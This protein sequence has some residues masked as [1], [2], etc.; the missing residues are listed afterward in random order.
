MS[1]IYD[2]LPNRIESEQINIHEPTK[3]AHCPVDGCDF[4]YWSGPNLLGFQSP[5]FG[6][7]TAKFEDPCE[8]YVGKWR[9]YQD[10][11]FIQWLKS[12]VKNE[13]QISIHCVTNASQN[14][15]VKGNQPSDHVILFIERRNQFK[16]TAFD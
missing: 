13:R 9:V 14:S 2:E 10:V 15:I 5:S 12:K 3:K 1:S 6:K 8:H 4:H 16:I 7:K 11:E